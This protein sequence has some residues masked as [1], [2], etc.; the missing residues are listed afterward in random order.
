MLK[1]TYIKF[2]KKFLHDKFSLWVCCIILFFQ[3]V[4]YF[5]FF[6]KQPLIFFPDNKNIQIDFYNDSVD[7]GNSIITG[8]YQTDSSTGMSFILKDGFIRPYVGIGFESKLHKEY[9]ISFFNKAKVEVTGKGIRPIFVYII[10]KDSTMN[11]DGKVL[12]FRHL[13]KYIEINSKRHFFKLSIADFKTP[14]WWFDKYNLSPTSIKQPYWSRMFRFAFATG[15]NPAQNKEQSIQ[16]YS[17][18]F[19]R[20]NTKVILAMF[21]IQLLVVTILFAFFYFMH[22]TRKTGK[23]FNN[24]L[25]CCCF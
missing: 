17:I 3:F 11:L 12:G 10:L 24:K 25:S 2:L 18:I 20:D 15:L 7:N 1:D 6:Q 8:T 14:D 9:N 23:N 16:I 5:T 4:I 19:Y 13:C 22:H 21:G